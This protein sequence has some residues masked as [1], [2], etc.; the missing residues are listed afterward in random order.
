MIAGMTMPP[1]IKDFSVT[2]EPKTWTMDGDTFIAPPTIPPMVL[3]DIAES[4]SALTNVAE[5]DLRGR[6]EAVANLFDM[7]LTPETAPRFRERLTAKKAATAADTIDLNKQAIPVLYWLLEEYGLRPTEPSE[8]SA[9]GHDGTG[10]S[11]TDTAPSA[12]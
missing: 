1:P 7:L 6:L 12:A 11:S 5:N 2:A 8:P 4:A 3:A 9:T 10:I